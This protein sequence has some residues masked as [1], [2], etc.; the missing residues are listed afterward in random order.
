VPLSGL[1][2][3]PE[4]VTIL[5]DWLKSYQAEELFDENGTL[6]PELQALA[7]VGQRRIGDN[8]HANGGY[9]Y[10]IY[11]FQIFINTPLRF[12]RQVRLKEKP[13]A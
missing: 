5:E 2:S 11:V 4:H 7:P 13:H 3:N 6:L 10:A 12:L 9:Y 8:P 1:A